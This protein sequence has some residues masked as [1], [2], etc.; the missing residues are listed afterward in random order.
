MTV[1][2]N[3]YFPKTSEAPLRFRMSIATALTLG[4]EL[5]I[6][7][8]TAGV[9]GIG[10]WIAH[11][12][13]LSLLRDRSELTFDLLEQRLRDH[14]NPMVKSTSAI[15]PLIAAGDIDLDNMQTLGG[16]HAWL[17][18]PNTTGH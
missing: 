13:T 8:T 12:N 4:F 16:A 2:A 5:L 6:L 7:V 15:T 1:P 10:L 3:E 18:C 14:I 17:S 9:L 11:E